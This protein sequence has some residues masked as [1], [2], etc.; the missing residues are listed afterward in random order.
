[1]KLRSTAPFGHG[2]VS[3]LTEP[4]PQGA[5]DARTSQAGSA[6]VEFAGSLILLAVMFAG[7]FEIGYSFYTYGT[8]V[9]AVRAGARY[10][11]LQPRGTSMDPSVAK[12]V[13][14]LVVYGDPAPGDATKP[15]VP[16]L[17]TE[18][19]EL[20]SGPDASTVSLRG[21]EVDALF[22]KVKLDGRP[23]VSFPVTNGAAQ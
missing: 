10:A 22:M 17:S 23:T 9:T 11:A 18:H 6:L 13:R 2:S 21:F 14:N 16:G 5:V 8:L 4:R 15:L 20:I 19:V 12:A 3:A 1:M 7:I